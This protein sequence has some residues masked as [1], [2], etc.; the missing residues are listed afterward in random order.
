MLGGFCFSHGALCGFLVTG[1]G[2]GLGF[3]LCLACGF[4]LLALQGCQALTLGACCSLGFGACDGG[5]ALLL[6]RPSCRGVD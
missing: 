2:S 6:S 5:Q 1:S 4:L 3:F